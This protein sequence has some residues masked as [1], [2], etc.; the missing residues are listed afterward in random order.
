MMRIYIFFLLV[1]V[2]AGCGK[3]RIAPVWERQ[4][5]HTGFDIS[6]VH[7]LD[8]Q[9]GFAVGGNSWYH[10]VALATADG[11]VTWVADSLGDKQLF[12]LDFNDQ[13]EGVAAGIDGY[14]FSR[15]EQETD[16]NFYRYT[17]WEIYRGVAHNG[18]ATLLV[19]GQAYKSG[20][21]ARLDEQFQFDTSSQYDVEL[22]AVCFA[23]E[24]VAIAVG[25]G[26]VLRSE[27]RGRS[28][29]PLP[30]DGDHF[31]AVHFPSASVGYIA[32]YAG[33]ILKTVDG[34]K[35]WKKLRN[36]GD[37]WQSNILVRSVFFKDEETGYLAGEKG[38]VWKTVNGGEDWTVLDGLPELDYY[39]VHVIGDEGWLVGEQGAIIHFRD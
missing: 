20:I 13:G 11:G 16:W 6:A 28:W 37:I 36:G 32:G 7:F 29:A 31:R 5:S 35:T 2:L 25:Y 17:I 30:V 23:D 33:T 39:D 9:R 19:G 14:V 8:G 4:V 3:E 22:D 26:L 18:K 15:K 34:G 10:G 1:L 21:L 12:A 27:N 38:V 24:Q